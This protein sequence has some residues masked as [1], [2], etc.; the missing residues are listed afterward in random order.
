MIIGRPSKIIFHSAVLVLA[1]SGT[2][3]RKLTDLR[4]D[5]ERTKT[6]M[7]GLRSTSEALDTKLRQLGIG[8]TNAS[9]LRTHAL[10]KAKLERDVAQSKEELAAVQVELTSLTLEVQQVESELNYYQSGLEK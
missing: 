2:S 1:L 6:E 8:G 5:V 3:C 7:Q 9:A 4:A 10:D